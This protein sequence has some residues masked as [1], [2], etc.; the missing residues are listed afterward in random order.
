LC[1][2][3][4]S[5]H[6]QSHISQCISDSCNIIQMPT[7]KNQKETA[8]G[9]RRTDGQEIGNER[10]ELNIVNQ[11]GSVD[12]S[13]TWDRQYHSK[14]PSKSLELKLCSSKS[15]MNQTSALLHIVIFRDPKRPDIS[16]ALIHFYSTSCRNEDNMKWYVFRE[17][18]IT[19]RLNW[20]S[21]FNSTKRRASRWPI[22]FSQMTI[23]WKH[24]VFQWRVSTETISGIKKVLTP[25]PISLDIKLFF[26][27]MPL[28]WII[29]PIVSNDPS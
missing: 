7:G 25:R 12:T 13:E 27:V 21:N 29:L 3:R 10:S 20:W 17:I 16:K 6:Y 24:K 1:R 5:Y 11:I 9:W 14:Q 15:E 22:N 28:V 26:E 23:G 8:Q 4:Q 18:R 19:N 2:S